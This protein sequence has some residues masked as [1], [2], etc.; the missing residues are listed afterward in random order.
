MGSRTILLGDLRE[1]IVS[2]QQTRIG[3]VHPAS[4]DVSRAVLD[5]AEHV[6]R[7][8]NGATVACADAWQA[9]RLERMAEARG[10]AGRIDVATVREIALGVLSDPEVQ[11]RVKRADRVLDGNEMDILI[12]DLKVTGLKT[13]RLKEMLSRFSRDISDGAAEAEGWPFKPEEAKLFAM[14]EENLE[15]RRACIPCEVAA[16]ACQ[17]LEAGALP[18]SRPFVACD[19]GALSAT[20]MRLLEILS[21]GEVI[22]F[23]TE[24]PFM[25]AEEPHPAPRGM[26]D[27]LDDGRTLHLEARAEGAPA[28]RGPACVLPTPLAEFDRIAQIIEEAG[29]ASD[30]GQL[31][32]AAPNATWCKHISRAI[33]SRGI[34][35]AVDLPARKVKGDPRDA[36]LSAGIRLA[37]FAKLLRDPDDFTAFRTFIGAG[38]WLVRS[39]GFLEL[40]AFAREHGMEARDA[41]RAM[42][43]PDALA[44]TT[45]SFRKLVGPINEYDKLRALWAEGTV[46]QVCEQMERHGM[47]LGKRAELLGD[48]GQ[49]PRLDAFL[50]SFDE[51]RSRPDDAS[52]LVTTYGR[53]HGRCCKTLVIAGM[54]DGFMPRR[55]AVDDAFD[56][57]HRKH[58][59]DRDRRFL[60]SIEAVASESV[61]RTS[62]DHDVLEN[63]SAM[64][65]VAARIY[66][67]DGRRMARVAQSSLLSE[68]DADRLAV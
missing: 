6:A 50:A 33:E 35:A 39:D 40:L 12:E 61:V 59:L 51:D 45:E 22:A 42:L 9:R 1:A 3:I 16:K 28:E 36:R 68:E 25:A 15:A 49:A 44:T 34:P 47:P 57:D 24:G 53:I 37:S 30:P 52:V 2:S 41:M 4:L 8:R 23:G 19:Y 48:P 46:A 66:H 14:L 21:G 27:F 13:Q 31:A 62:F 58:A 67:K 38:D 56:I 17:G 29:G 10:I 60:E 65:V 54:V 11:S 32:V 26:R 7:G 20:G 55:D 18:E 43:E 64:D 5:A 63:I